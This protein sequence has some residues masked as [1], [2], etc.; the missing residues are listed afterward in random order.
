[1]YM[2]LAAKIPARCMGHFFCLKC[3]WTKVDFSRLMSGCAV[4]RFINVLRTKHNTTVNDNCRLE[5]Y[6]HKIM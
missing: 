4:V 6:C 1:M 2:G 3:K 5:L